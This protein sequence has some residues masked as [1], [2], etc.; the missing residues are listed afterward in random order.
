VFGDRSGQER[1]LYFYVWIVRSSGSIGII[2]TGLPSGDDLAAL[3][4][5]GIYRDIVGLNEVLD[6]NDIGPDDIDWC[7]VTQPITYHSGGLLAKYLPRAE[8]HIAAAGVYEF[9]TSPPGHPPAETYFTE[10]SWTFLRTLAIERRLHLAD[11]ETE[12]A[13]GVAFEPTGGHHPG[14]A[15]VR[16]A[17]EEGTVGILET[18]F[19]QQNISEGVPIGIAEN[20]A[21]CR[22]AIERYTRICDR[23]I[24]GHEPGNVEVYP[25]SA[26]R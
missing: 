11:G 7:A 8:V 21:E 6:R 17:T 14:S 5:T 25:E 22:A 2:D 3:R 9:L 19:V 26:E 15:A 1:E 13:P 20:T 23:V 10:A 16:V 18:A 4:T 24:A 12:I